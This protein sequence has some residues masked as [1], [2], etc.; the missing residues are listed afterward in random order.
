MKIKMKYID[1]E[2][3]RVYDCPVCRSGE[4]RVGE[5]VFYGKCDNCG[6]SLIDYEPL[7]YQAFYHQST[8]Q[9]K[10]S[11]GGYGT[12]KT[13]MACA[14]LAVHAQDVTGG[15]SLITGPTLALIKD[16]VIPELEK[17][18]PPWLIEHKRMNPS[19]Y[20]KLKNGHEIITYASTDQQK[21]RSLNLS[22]FYI[23]E[24]SAVDYAIFDQL[25][26]R[27]RHKAAIIRDERGAEV[28][29]KYLGLISTNPEEGWIK[30]QFLF[31]ADRV[32]ASNSI[33]KQIYEPLMAI[34]RQKHFHAF[35][36]STRDNP[37]IPAEFIQRM[38]AGKSPEWIRVYIDC[39]LDRRE[40]AV[41]PDFTKHIVEPFEVPDH[42]VRIGGFDPGY[43]DGTALVLAAISPRDGTIY[44]YDD[45]YETERPVSYHAEQAKKRVYGLKFYYP[46]QADPSVKKRNE[47]DGISYADYFYRLS[48]V[49]FENANNDILF[50]IE[51]VR[52]YMQA[53]K[54]KIF[55]SCV[56]IKREAANYIYK[57]STKRNSNDTPIDRYNHLMDAMRYMIVRL[58]RDPNEMNGALTERDVDFSAGAFLS[59]LSREDFGYNQ[60]NI[61]GGMSYGREKD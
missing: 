17:F 51:K 39:Y 31:V 18:L 46:I 30:D 3:H 15:R 50:G 38:S 49:S 11:I 59:D 40:G 20:F 8:A 29:Y 52:D 37:H 13:T 58:P 34:D 44:I 45:Y 54:L 5:Q 1:G 2:G 22:A 6:A 53:G 19:P 33:D 61:F 12:G 57:D 21:L 27:L 9:Y 16:A 24:A 14:E 41:Y 56:N 48:D 25:M 55:S 35:I 28:G 23:E 32:H 60:Q 4:T 43:T 36:S 42:W 10:L 7:N 47:R 26:T